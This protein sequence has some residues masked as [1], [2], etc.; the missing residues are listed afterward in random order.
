MKSLI[1]IGTCGFGREV[2]WLVELI[3]KV[4]PTWNILGY[5]DD[6][7]KFQNKTVNC[8]EILENV[9]DGISRYDQSHLYIPLDLQK[10][11]KV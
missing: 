5:L 6:D 10:F 2:A 1:I 7:E 4:K 3:N 9:S 8:Y 11:D